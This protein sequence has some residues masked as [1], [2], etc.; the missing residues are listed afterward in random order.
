M[1]SRKRARFSSVEERDA[2]EFAMLCKQPQYY[3][4]VRLLPANSLSLH[5]WIMVGTAYGVE[6]LNDSYEIP[7]NFMEE[8]LKRFG[9]Q[10]VK[11]LLYELSSY[12][13]NIVDINM[14][15]FVNYDILSEIYFS[16]LQQ[17]FWDCETNVLPE[18]EILCLIMRHLG[19]LR[20]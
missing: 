12:I 6:S 3:N 7:E 10:Q 9:V 13:K 16:I 19:R 15:L 4:A 11:H 14:S 2:I 17:K 18:L 20:V 1:A 8:N 5:F